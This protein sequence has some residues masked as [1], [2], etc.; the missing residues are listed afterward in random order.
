MVSFECEE[1]RHQHDPQQFILGIVPTH[2]LG[3]HGVIH[4]RVGA[5]NLRAPVFHDQAIAF[6]YKD[7]DTFQVA[8]MLIRTSKSVRQK[9]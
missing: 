3:A 4:V 8:E 9:R 6:N 7:G 2:Q 1:F 5:R